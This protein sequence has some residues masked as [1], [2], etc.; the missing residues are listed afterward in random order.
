MR[1]AESASV[2][3]RNTSMLEQIK[4]LKA[5]PPF[6]G[7]RR[8][9]AY[10]RFARGLEVNKKRIY[11]LMQRY[12]LLVKPNP[13]LK[14][15]RTPHRSKPRPERPNQ[16]W[17]MDMTKVRVAGF[18]WVY[19]AFIVDWYSK[20]IVGYYTGMQ[21]T[22]KHW[23]ETLE[24]AVNRQL[25]EGVRGKGLSLM[26][27]NG[28]QPTSMGFMKACSVLGIS[29]AF[30]SYNNPKGNADTERLFRTLKEE[31]LWLKEWTSPLELADEVAAWVESYNTTYLHSALDY[32]A[33]VQAETDYFRS[34][35]TLILIT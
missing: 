7:Y 12:G 15:L 26:C 24:M 33:P 23:L 30:T 35:P 29:Q 32:R 17:G 28:C 22:A 5:E 4:E 16:W 9:W 8:V 18:G 21:C 2:I 34:Q 10:L 20:K 13:R 1:R 11:R 31:L 25:S 19:I 6:W 14:A 27:D 3:E